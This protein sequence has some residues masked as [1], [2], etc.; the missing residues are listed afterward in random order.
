MSKDCGNTTSKSMVF[1][2]A[3]VRKCI[4]LAVD[5]FIDRGRKIAKKN[6]VDQHKLKAGTGKPRH[7][8]VNSIERSY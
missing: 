4:S 2:C 8:I 1:E 3:G 5:F 7:Y 6:K